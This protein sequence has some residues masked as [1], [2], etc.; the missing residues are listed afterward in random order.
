MAAQVSGKEEKIPE[1][2]GRVQTVTVLVAGP[3]S[4]AK[5]TSIGV[6]VKG[7]LDAPDSPMWMEVDRHRHEHESKNTSS[8]STHYM[9][10]GTKVVELVNLCGHL[11]YLKQTFLG[12]TGQG[13]DYAILAINVIDGLGAASTK[14]DGETVDM[15]LE[16][17]NALVHLEIPFLIVLTKVDS[18]P[19]GTPADGETPNDVK[20]R[21]GSQADPPLLPGLRPQGSGLEDGQE[22][23]PQGRLL[24]IR[25]SL[26]HDMG[27]VPV[28]CTSNRTGIERAEECLYR[29]PPRPPWKASDITADVFFI[30]SVYRPPHFGI[31]VAGDVKA[32]APIKVGE[33]WH[34]GPH[35]TG[36][37]TA[38]VPAKSTRFTTT[39]HER[40]TRRSLS[41]SLASPDAYACAGPRMNCGARTSSR[42]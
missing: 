9:Q 19:K 26:A 6:L 7:K 34:V 18:I 5:S 39:I 15:G 4:S 38:F 27:I 17:L 14:A 21:G 42:A 24:G 37:T 10:R 36:K 41:C 13:A 1:P 2:A 35:T 40:I 11:R 12:M 3:V 16:H 23:P 22:P 8:I 25:R 29:L 30:T 33:I 20:V 28:I 32:R 31:I